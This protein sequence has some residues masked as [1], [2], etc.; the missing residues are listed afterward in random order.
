MRE[1]ASALHTAVLAH[2][3]WSGAPGADGPIFAS[4]TDG[5]KGIFTEIPPGSM[6]KLATLGFVPESDPVFARTYRWLHSPNYKY[7]WSD[8]TFGLP[9]S[10]RLPFTTSWSVADHLHLSAGHD[11]ALRI[12]RASRWDG[13]I[14]TEGVDP[15]SARIDPAGRAFAIAAGYV[16]HAICESMCKPEGTAPPA[17]GQSGP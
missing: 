16:A 11:L 7:S 2:C 12:L 8:K 3:V 13:G 9:G 6:M 5:A 17:G 4:A 1:R 15:G 14:V 10:Y